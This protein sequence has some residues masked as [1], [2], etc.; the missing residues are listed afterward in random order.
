MNEH[1]LRVGDMVH[2][3]GIDGKPWKPF[4]IGVVTWIYSEPYR[5][6]TAH[7]A[8]VVWGGTSPSAIKGAITVEKLAHVRFTDAVWEKHHD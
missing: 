5:G 2:Y 7:A 1:H 4:G 6:R 8:A 3:V